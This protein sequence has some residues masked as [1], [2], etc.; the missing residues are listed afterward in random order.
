MTPDDIK[1]AL[2]NAVDDVVADRGSYVKDL[3]HFSRNTTLNMKQTMKLLLCMSG[4]ALDKELLV[5]KIKATPSAFVQ[6]RS[7]ISPNAFYT[8]FRKFNQSCADEG[9]FRGFRVIAAD[10]SG[11]PSQKSATSKNFLQ[12]EA[13]PQGICLNYANYLYDLINQVYIDICLGKNEQDKLIALLYRNKF[14]SPTILIL[15]RGYESYN[16]IVHCCDKIPNLYMVLRVKQDHGALRDVKSL[17]LEEL[18]VDLETTVTDRQ[19]NFSK[20]N[21]FV[22]LQTGSKRGKVNK[23]GT[24]IKRFDHAM[25]YTVKC[26]AVRFRLSSGKYETLLTNLPRDTFSA[27]ELKDLYAMRWGIETSFNILKNKVGM[28]YLHSKRDELIEQEFYSALCMYNLTS[29][30]NSLV[31]MPKKE[32]N[33]YAYKVDFKMSVYLCRE[34]LRNENADGTKLLEEISSYKVPIRPG[35]SGSRN[36]K[37]KGAVPFV[38]RVA[39]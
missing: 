19:D 11:L 24:R 14:L 18:D 16:T 7:K 8:V 31:A 32:E 17:P 35:R 4:G 10:G 26:R 28:A 22:F 3:R 15:D 20:Q 13:Y 2:L 36:I 37:V 39:A 6:Q 29:R 23:P 1:D 38:Y 25:P 9:R 5:N 30:I 33:I 12:S 21:N 34:F 27:T